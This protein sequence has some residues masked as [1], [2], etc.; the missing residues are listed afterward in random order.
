MVDSITRRS[1]GLRRSSRKLR[2]LSAAIAVSFAAGVSA[3]A[4]ELY[5]S[6]GLNIRWNN[7]LQY[8]EA[9]RIS[10]PDAALVSNPNSNEGDRN[11]APGLISNRLDLLSVLDVTEGDF[12]IQASVE[13]WYDTV[14]HQRTAIGT[15]F[16]PA[17]RNLEGQYAD[18]ADTF[19][20]GNFF[21]GDAPVTIRA[22]RQTLLWGESLFFDDN[23]IAAA[24]APVDYVRSLDAPNAYSNDVYLPVDQVS[25]T[26][27]PRSDISLSA[28][29]QFIWRGSRLPGVGSYFSTTNALGVGA[30]RL[31]VGPGLFLQHGT[32][33]V[34]TE[35]QFGV[36]LRMI[37]SDVDLGLY[38]L[39]YDAKYPVLE[40][41]PFN[42]IPFTPGYSGRFRSVY[43]TGIQLYGVSFST[44]LGDS[45][46]AGELAARL[47]TPLNN[48][49]PMTSYSVQTAPH[50][51]DDYALGNTLHTQVSSVTTLP[52]ASG[53]N[54]ADISVEF[55]AN[56]ILSVSENA[57]A[58]DLSQNRFA[59]KIRAL[60]EPHYFEVLPD[61]EVSLPVGLGYDLSGQYRSVYA[62]NA[63]AGDVEA[64]ISA[65]YMS[66]WKASL[67]FTGFFGGP[68]RQPL[69]DRD[70]VAIS[71]ERTF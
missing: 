6:D 17:T 60:F 59:T 55:A 22:G 30:E 40:I 29:Y 2:N 18:L 36:S 63:G 34:P 10:S 3:R 43:P 69:A 19:A 42:G 52:P 53:W 51:F 24:Q 41:A 58:F 65:S 9:S 21:I 1:T 49:G 68:S 20:Y 67:S 71:L 11:F 38:A 15:K 48:Y 26:A 37:E 46:V 64:G 66:V 12:G 14:Y 35:G 23:S 8:S 4:A 56:Y 50:A 13:A 33:Q 39:R 7:T 57:P 28:Y 44:Y 45:N 62:E 31:F 32:D 5:E 25:I 61:L 16:S 70:F 54:S 27:Q 47:N